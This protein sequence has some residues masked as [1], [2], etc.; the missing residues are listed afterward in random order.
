MAKKT[1][2]VNDNI[3]RIVDTETDRLQMEIHV[4]DKPD[5]KHWQTFLE[6]KALETSER[7]Y[8]NRCRKYKEA[9]EAR[10][11]RLDAEAEA[12]YRRKRITAARSATP[13]LEIN[14]DVQTPEQLKIAEDEGRRLLESSERQARELA[15][16]RQERRELDDD[17]RKKEAEAAQTEA[18]AQRMRKQLEEKEKARIR[19][20]RA[21]ED[22]IL[23]DDTKKAGRPA[24]PFPST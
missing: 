17:A 19:K 11:A 14:V 20:K 2:T 21:K 15:L 13:P 8:Q 10:A 9:S 23:L 12:E 18:L 6:Q 22:T 5:W 16:E 24:A 1:P 3:L 4:D 7:F